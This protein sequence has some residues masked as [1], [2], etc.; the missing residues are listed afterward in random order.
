MHNNKLASAL[1]DTLARIASSVLH[2][3]N[4]VGVHHIEATAL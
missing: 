1:A 3:G 4:S 2:K